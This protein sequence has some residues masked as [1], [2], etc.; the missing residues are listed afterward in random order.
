MKLITD[1]EPD[2]SVVALVAQLLADVDEGRL[3]ASKAEEPL[4]R[5]ARGL[6]IG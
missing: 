1:R 3:V 2:L 5:A 6:P 4:T